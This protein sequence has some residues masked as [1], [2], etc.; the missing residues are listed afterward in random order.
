MRL[1]FGGADGRAKAGFTE[2]AEFLVAMG[3]GGVDTAAALSRRRLRMPDYLQRPPTRFSS[4]MPIS[5]S[6]SCPSLTAGSHVASWQKS[7]GHDLD[8]F[9]RVA[10]AA[11]DEAELQAALQ[12]RFDGVMFRRAAG[13]VF[14]GGG[15][16]VRIG[17]R[18]DVLERKERWAFRSEAVLLIGDGFVIGSLGS[19]V[20]TSIVAARV[21]RGQRRASSGTVRSVCF[22]RMGSR[23]R[24]SGR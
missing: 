24:H 7:A 2:V 21:Q 4:A 17:R 22:M 5:P 16:R 11:E 20:V 14:V 3:G 15:P 8:A 18:G 13:G 9:V 1:R 12:V 23:H 6:D 10:A 19:P